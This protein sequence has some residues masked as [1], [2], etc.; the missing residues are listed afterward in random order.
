MRF[1]DPARDPPARF[2]P[3]DELRFRI[4]EVIR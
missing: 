2:R 4:A 1:F 3:G